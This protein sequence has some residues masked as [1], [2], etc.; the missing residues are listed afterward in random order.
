[1][2]AEPMPPPTAADRVHDV[3][4]LRL[5]LLRELEDS[6]GRSRRALLALDL[7]GI[8]RGTGEQL[9]LLRQIAAAGRGGTAM[10]ADA[11]PPGHEEAHAW[12]AL[13]P[14]LEKELRASQSRILEAARLHLALLARARA[15]LHVLAN[16]LAG[17]SADYGALL[18]KSRGPSWALA[19][20]QS[21]DI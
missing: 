21:G 9:G 12:A 19:L 15:K 8:E 3:M 4:S 11:I 7:G 20:K 17:P 5:A 18:A 2:S 16:V 1:M 14:A 10:S 13:S 6:L